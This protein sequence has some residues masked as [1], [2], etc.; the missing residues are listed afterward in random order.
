MKNKLLYKARAEIEKRTFSLTLHDL[1]CKKMSTR[2][3]PPYCRPEIIRFSESLRH[4]E[5]ETPVGTLTDTLDEATDKILGHTVR[6]VEP[7]ALVYLPSNI[8]S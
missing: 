7:E 2:W 8:L 1:K 4:V 3:L 5:A 6:H